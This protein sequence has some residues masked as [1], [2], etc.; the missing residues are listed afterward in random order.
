MNKVFDGHFHLLFK[1]F[2]G[3]NNDMG[4]NMRLTGLGQSLDEIFGGTFDSQSSPELVSRSPLYVGVCSILAMEHAFANRVLV[5]F[6]IPIGKKNLPLNWNKVEKIKNSETTYYDDF[7]DQLNFYTT[8]RANLGK[9]PFHIHFTGRQDSWHQALG[10]K[11]LYEKL[12]GENKKRYLVMSIEGGHNLSNVPIKGTARSL[13]PEMQMEALQALPDWDFMSLNLC[14]LSDI[15]EQSLGGFCQGLNKSAQVAFRSDDFFPKSD[16]GLTYLGKKVIDQCLLH[17]EKPV[18]IDIK[19]MSAYTRFDYYAYRE[20]LIQDHPEV[21]R[22][23]I[24]STHT[25]FTFT[26][27]GDYVT[28]QPYKLEKSLQNGCT[29]TPENRRIGRTTQR[30][31]NDLFCNP[32]S[33][34]LFDE[35]IVE[36][37]R[38]GGLMGISL[39]K[40][41]LGH[42]KCFKDGKRPRYYEEEVISE[43]EFEKLFKH[44]IFPTAV[45]GFFEDLLKVPTRAER[46]IM[47]LCLHLVHAVRIGYAALPWMENTSPWDHLCIGSD[48][49]GLINP[50]NGYDNITDLT[51]MRADLKKHLPLA[52]ML[53]E[54]ENKKALKYVDN[55]VD[56]TFLNEVVEKVMFTNGVKMVGRFLKNWPENWQNALV[57]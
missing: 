42:A 46:H 11:A 57:S 39:D 38:S 32:W 10:L 1:H 6:G 20:Q 5:K 40:R 31:N 25:G 21:D 43:P 36:I 18:L 35:E 55:K 8:H 16:L 22:L 47:L 14:H 54:G 53:I 24:V 7:L 28:K 56:A 48:Y 49:D 37:M 13:N 52:D 17:P 9:A 51:K 33:I 34:N 4:E 41:V 2:I 44:G 15:P 23:P 3:T 19:H 30:N 26:G 27:L 12:L 29:V 45:E 50:I